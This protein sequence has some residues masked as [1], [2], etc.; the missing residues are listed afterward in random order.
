MTEQ[1]ELIAALIR[2]RA[3]VVSPP[4]EVFWYTSGT[5]GPYYINT[6]YL[7]GGPEPAPPF[8]EAGGDPTDDGLTCQS[9][10]P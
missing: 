2:T 6:H 9:T 10:G 3:L 1:T 7:L 8:P 5:V 4:G